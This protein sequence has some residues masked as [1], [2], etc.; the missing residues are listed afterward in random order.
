[1]REIKIG[2]VIVAYEDISHNSISI[3]KSSSPE[4]FFHIP[5]INTCNVFLERIMKINFI[6][7]EEMDE[8]LRIIHPDNWNTMDI[9]DELQM[10]RRKM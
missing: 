6:N 1:M 3:S 4:M 9:I 5:D 8:I 2:S 7:N 10:S